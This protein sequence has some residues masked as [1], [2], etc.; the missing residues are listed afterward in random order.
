M[1][2]HNIA[3]AIEMDVPDML[4]DHRARDRPVRVTKQEFQQ[5]VFLQFEIDNLAG[6]VHFMR[7]RI[8]FQVGQF[9]SGALLFAAA[10]QGADTSGEL[11][12]SERLGEV[13]V[14][15]GVKPGD[16]VW[17]DG[18]F[19][20]HCHAMAVCDRCKPDF[21]RHV[22]RHR[23]APHSSGHRRIQSCKDNR[24]PRVCG[25]H[26]PHRRISAARRIRT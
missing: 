1:H 3:D 26:G 24:G 15:A 11:G 9:Q 18:G 7:G 17:S 13:V 25:V 19:R 21:D 14:G 8:Q 10:Q 2:V 20:L 4:N 22:L 12:E 6:A 16:L 5:R 23:R